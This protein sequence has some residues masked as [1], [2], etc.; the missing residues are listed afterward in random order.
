MKEKL[1]SRVKIKSEKS[2][3]RKNLKNEK[4]EEELE[5][6]DPLV[7]KKQ[8]I[9]YFQKKDISYYKKKIIDEK[10]M[11]HAINRIAMEL[12]HFILKDR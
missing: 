11:E 5:D 6:L 4:W 1:N 9:T 7:L 3:I 2:N 12:S 8:G 10:Y